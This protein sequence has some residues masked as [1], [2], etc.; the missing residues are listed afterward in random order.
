LCF[1]L[2]FTLAIF[3]FSRL[4]TL[5]LPPLPTPPL[6]HTFSLS[7]THTC[8]PRR[9][10]RAYTLVPTL[11]ASRTLSLSLPALSRTLLVRP[12]TTQHTTPHCTALNRTATHT[13]THFATHT[14]TH[15]LSS[16]QCGEMW[17]GVVQ[18]VAVC[19][20]AHKLTPHLFLSH[21]CIP[22]FL[23]PSHTNTFHI[24]S[25]SLAYNKR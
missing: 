18:R 12:R 4:L 10:E 3:S 17:C 24:P 13:A 8:V 25:L 16:V 22:L 20:S 5:P 14:A 9:R 21:P 2:S 1:L 19:C 7:Q 11:S 23:P 6:S 15:S